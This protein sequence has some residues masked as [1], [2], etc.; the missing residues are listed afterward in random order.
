M[1]C[2]EPLVE[3]SLSKYL[4]GTCAIVSVSCARLNGSSSF[5]VCTVATTQVQFSQ[6]VCYPA[7]KKADS[8]RAEIEENLSLA[9]A[10][11]VCVLETFNNDA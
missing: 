5:P 1:L 11:Q 2:N 3:T 10:L 8:E 7:K 9:T 6:D 4:V